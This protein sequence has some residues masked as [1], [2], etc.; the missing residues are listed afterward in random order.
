ME[1]ELFALLIEVLN[2]LEAARKR[3]PKARFADRHIV[4]VFLWAVLHDRPVSWACQRRNWPAHDRTRLL[5]SGSTMSRRLRSAAVLD[6]IEALRARLHV[7]VLNHHDLLMLDAKPS[8]VSGHSADP[9]A[10]CGRASAGMARGYKAHCIADSAGN[11]R[12]FEVV[13]MN[14]SE[15]TMAKLLL[16]RLPES[17]GMVLLAD[18]NYDCNELYDLAAAKGVQLIAAPRKKVTKGLGHTRHSP[19]RLR[20]MSIRTGTPGVLERRRWIEGQFGTLGNVVGGLSPLPNHVRRLHRVKRW[21]TGKLIVDALHR[22]Q[23]RSLSA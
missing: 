17:P 20:A 7:P 11:K 8:P 19:H 12:V 21:F 16:Q 1:R 9:E 14:I 15:V 18:G 6:L 5:P 2:S 22:R 3:P 23:R 4:L 10:R 13:P